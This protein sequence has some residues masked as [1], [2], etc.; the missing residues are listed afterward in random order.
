MDEDVGFFWWESGEGFRH[1][2][3]E[4]ENGCSNVVVIFGGGVGTVEDARAF[5][6]CA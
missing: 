6:R 5:G 1:E 2:G 3:G 4:R